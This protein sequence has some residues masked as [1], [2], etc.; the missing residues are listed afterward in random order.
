MFE[1]F[2]CVS[3]LQMRSEYKWTSVMQR[4]TAE[5]AVWG[6]L[7][8]LIFRLHRHKSR[9]QHVIEKLPKSTNTY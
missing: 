3:K 8:C 9:Q 5:L 6:Q 1:K 4:K 7:P 2:V